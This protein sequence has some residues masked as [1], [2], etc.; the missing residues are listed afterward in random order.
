MDEHVKK[1]DF[2]E[3]FFMES[4]EKRYDSGDYFGA[5]KMLNMRA[6]RYD[7]S[8]DAE[9][10]YAD[11]FEALG[12]YPLCA[13]AWFRFLD[14]CNEADFSEG[15]EGLS[16]AFM[17]MGDEFHSKIY[18]GKTFEAEGIAAE[19]PLEEERR[20][21]ELKLVH[22]EDGSVEDEELMREGIEHVKNGDF[23]KAREA[24][25]K[26]QKNGKSYP[27]ATGL[28]AICRLLEGDVG[29]A[30]LEC[31]NFLA[32]SPDNVYAL[33]TY[34]A[35]LGARGEMEEARKVGE[36]LSTLKVDSIEDT[37]RIATALCE[38]GLDEQAYEKLAILKEKLPYSEDI[39]W[40]HAV[41][42]YRTGRIEEAI[43]SLETLTLLNPRKEIAIEHLQDMRKE[44]DGEGEGFELGY[45]YRIPKERRSDIILLFHSVLSADLEKPIPF[46][47]EALLSCLKLAFDQPTGRDDELQLLA[48][49]VAVVH[50]FDKLVRDVL[51][52]YTV[53]E[54]VKLFMLQQLV[55]RNEDNS[56]G[57]VLCNFYREFYTH[58]IDIGEEYSEA[59]LSAFG[60]VYARYAL[61]QDGN[62]E[63]LAAAAEDV[64]R[65]L[66]ETGNMIY[67]G[68]KRAIRAVIFREARL[69]QPQRTLEEICAL[70]NADEKKVKKILDLIL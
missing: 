1:L 24:L 38:T 19:F 14:T 52:N 69:G 36:R 23:A 12:L 18:L 13:D 63:K 45:F 67:A 17:N 58:E 59:Y 30:A 28:A 51:L 40:F 65:T 35:V 44:R 49:E 15:F 31:E 16:V 32:H 60:E 53:D 9:A 2:Q 62:E 48:G 5:L 37:Y 27:A 4:A 50:H 57:V 20:K 41:S 46:K 47:S 42:A 26:V 7:P 25:E 6:E 64:Y 39:L 29:G 66:E 21:P 55:M 10:L 61:L 34:C 43:S 11:I 33:T 8:A 70:F 68:E 22:S 56:F 3:E 54:G